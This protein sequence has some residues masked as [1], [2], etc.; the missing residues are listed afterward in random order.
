VKDFEV[1][2]E[3]SEFWFCQTFREKKTMQQQKSHLR[4]F[5]L[6]RGASVFF[7]QTNFL[8]TPTPNFPFAPSSRITLAD[9][10]QTFHSCVR[11]P[12]VFRR[13][14]T[15]LVTVKKKENFF[16]LLI[17]LFFPIFLGKLRKILSLQFDFLNELP[18]F[19]PPIY[20]P[21]SFADILPIY[22]YVKFSLNLVR[23]RKS[24]N[25]FVPFLYS[26]FTFHVCV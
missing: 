14:R 11:C 1:Y 25:I 7:Q 3:F 26:Y 10:S 13:V 2:S 8:V 17:L 24:P 4:R 19:R 22:R 23:K 12:K 18:I 9:G 21:G 5:L 15:P 20:G 16:L 6:C